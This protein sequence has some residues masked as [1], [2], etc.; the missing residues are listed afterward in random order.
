MYVCKDNYIIQE[1][2]VLYTSG[3]GGLF[4]AG[5]PIGKIKTD[6]LNLNLQ[7]RMRTEF[8]REIYSKFNFQVINSKTDKPKKIEEGGG[9]FKFSF[10]YILIVNGISNCA[11]LFFHFQNVLP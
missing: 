11:N 3:S 1:N 2:S 6:E 4:K 9:I 8:S 7:N 5:I 10:F